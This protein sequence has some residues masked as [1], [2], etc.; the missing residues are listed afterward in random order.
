MATEML[1]K[2]HIFYSLLSHITI[3][4]M[5]SA[6]FLFDNFFLVPLERNDLYLTFRSKTSAVFLCIYCYNKYTAKH[7]DDINIMTYLWQHNELGLNVND[8]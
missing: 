8:E 3:Q 2:P 7:V 6:R 5:V 4:F 1:R